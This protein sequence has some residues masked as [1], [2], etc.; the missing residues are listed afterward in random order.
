MCA[1]TPDKLVSIFWFYLALLPVTHLRGE[2]PGSS[3]AKH[4]ESKNVLQSWIC[5]ICTTC[6][7]LAFDGKATQEHEH[8]GHHICLAVPPVTKSSQARLCRAH[9]LQEFGMQP[10][11]SDEWFYLALPPVAW[12]CSM[13]AREA[14]MC[15]KSRKRTI[16][17]PCKALPL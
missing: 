14:C 13:R 17:R 10:A 7:F 1:S 3:H 5:T 15:R 8:G 4:S 9:K 12:C 6:E 11:C 16:L 2:A